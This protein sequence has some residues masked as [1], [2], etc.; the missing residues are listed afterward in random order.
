M[1]SIQLKL[2]DGNKMKITYKD[3]NLSAAVQA[4]S[5]VSKQV[6]RL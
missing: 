1:Q 2:F 3:D 6:L 5:L 4:V